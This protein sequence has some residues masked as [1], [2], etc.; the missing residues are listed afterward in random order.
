MGHPEIF[1][2]VEFESGRAFAR[3]PTLFAMRLRKGWGTPEF[4][5]EMDLEAGGAEGVRSPHR[6]EAAMNGAPGDFCLG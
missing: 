6:G 1:V 5:S 3:Y 4:L 2:W